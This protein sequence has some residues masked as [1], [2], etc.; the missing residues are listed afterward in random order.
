MSVAGQNEAAFWHSDISKNDLVNVLGG[1]NP[2]EQFAGL[3]LE[4]GRE[5]IQHII[6][7]FDQSAF[8]LRDATA[9]DRF[10]ACA[11]QFDGQVL[12]RHA[13]LIP[14]LSDLPA[15]HVQLSHTHTHFC[16]HR[17]I[18]YQID[19]ST[20]CISY[21]KSGAHPALPLEFELISLS[22]AE[23]SPASCSAT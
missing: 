4:D 18:L 1:I 15:D 9:C 21:T 12:L 5:T 6:R 2:G 23:N 17:A 16:S 7:D 10:P 8:D 11:V 19:C 20:G 14:Q 13:S 3:N 22:L